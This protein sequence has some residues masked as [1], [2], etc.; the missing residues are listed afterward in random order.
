MAH[1]TIQIDDQITSEAVIE[2]I[3]NQLIVTI[4]GWTIAGTTLLLYPMLHLSDDQM[5][6]LAYRLQVEYNYTFGC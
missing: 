2:F 3:E 6:D 4:E 5:I 1:I